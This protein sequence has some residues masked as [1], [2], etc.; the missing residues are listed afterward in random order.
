LVAQ[1]REDLEGMIRLGRVELPP[2]RAVV[3]S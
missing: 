3:A 2:M 1:A